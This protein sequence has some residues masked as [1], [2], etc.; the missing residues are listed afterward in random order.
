MSDRTSVGWA[1][2]LSPTY[3]LLGLI[4][5]FPLLA[6]A[7]EANKTELPPLHHVVWV[8]PPAS[9][10]LPPE[11]SLN[12]QGQI[13][14][15]TCHGIEDIDTTPI[16]QVDT[17][18]D[19]FHRGGPY[20]Q[21]TDFCYRCHEV[22]DY[23]RPNIHKLLDDNDEYEEKE[24]EYCHKIVPD[25]KKEIKREALEFRL[26]PQKLCWGC[27]LKTPHLNAVNHLV[28]TDQDMRERMVEA[29]KNYQIILPLDDDGRIMCSTC[30][31]SHESGVIAPDKPAGKQVADTDLKTGVSYEGHPW[32]EVFQA[33]KKTRLEELAQDGGG[34]HHLRYRR[35]KTEVLL[36]LPAKD[37][38]LCQACHVFERRE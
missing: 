13:D 31:T 37:G 27:H 11:F 29:E 7:Q 5:F 24:C 34:V 30:H 26:P 9:M 36:R 1:S 35:L 2:C 28:E 6:L 8:K 4:L 21:L 32:D 14:C 25:P 23:Q 20:S 17:T 3:V 16:D 18:A 10:K 19:N 38:T 15:K 33:D 12:D 22:E